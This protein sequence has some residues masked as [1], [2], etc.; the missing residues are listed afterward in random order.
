MQQCLG[1]LYR[2]WEFTSIDLPASMNMVATPMAAQSWT[3]QRL[4]NDAADYTWLCDQAGNFSHL[5]C[6][7]ARSRHL[8]INPRG[9]IVENFKT[10]RRISRLLA[11]DDGYTF[12]DFPPRLVRMRRYQS[13]SAIV[14][15]YT[16]TKNVTH[17]FLA[18]PARMTEHGAL[19]ELCNGDWA[20]DNLQA[21]P[22]STRLHPTQIHT[23][24]LSAPGQLNSSQINRIAVLCCRGDP[25]PS[26]ALRLSAK[27]RILH[28][29]CSWNAQVSL[30]SGDLPRRPSKLFFTTH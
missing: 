29:V 21:H 23:S 26:K 19:N 12:I 27:L 20:R 15:Q 5:M 13:T 4:D 16:D 10:H 8:D 2:Q 30:L 6:P 22:V 28:C 17:G 11:N 1:L 25:S 14:G 24:S 3:L 7:A 9:R 18:V